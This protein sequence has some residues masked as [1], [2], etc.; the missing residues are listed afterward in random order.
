MK[1]VSAIVFLSAL[2][3]LPLLAGTNSQKFLLP[4]DVRIGDTQLREGH[5][6]VVWTQPAGSQVQLTIKT[7]DQ[8]TITV[9]AQMVEG[10]QLDVAVQT[11][12]ANGVTYVREFDTKKAR[13]IVQ[14]PKDVK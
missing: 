2:F 14:D 3:S 1:R 11:F 5:C 4:S 12:V 7:E 9:P 13:F 8:K 10:K 6:E